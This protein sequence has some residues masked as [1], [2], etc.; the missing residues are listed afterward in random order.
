MMEK[1]DLENAVLFFFSDH[2]LRS[3][4]T[5]FAKTPVG[6]AESNLPFLFLVIPPRLKKLLPDLVVNARNNVRRLVT[7]F[8]IHK[9]L[10]HLLHLQTTNKSSESWSNE[11][12]D[13]TQESFSLLTP[14]PKNRTCDRAGISP[15]YCS[16][17]AMI[18]TNTS[19]AATIAA[20][21]ALIEAINDALSK[22]S[23][24]CEVWKVHQIIESNK[25]TEAEE[26]SIQVETRPK[27]EF[28]GWVDK[29]R[30]WS[31]AKIDLNQVWRND[32]YGN[33]SACVLQRDY[34]LK[35]YCLCKQ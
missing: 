3:R 13:G 35:E 9:T 1:G 18:R 25:R 2:G 11:A 21:A 10:Q 5:E 32:I 24:I 29:R 20:G 7:A 33:T 22:V 17:E 31:K 27:A 28:Q 8:D 4:N 14:V 19:S 6:K 23:D 26:Y 16:C 34:S 30:G 15:A 12:N